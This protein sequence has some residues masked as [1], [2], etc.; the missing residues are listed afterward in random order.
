MLHKLWG[1]NV[2]Y[3]FKIPDYYL[4]S[5]CQGK[6]DNLHKSINKQAAVQASYS[7]IPGSTPT[8]ATHIKV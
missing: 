3:T 6:G 7:I 2:T 1:F 5:L 4:R 8:V